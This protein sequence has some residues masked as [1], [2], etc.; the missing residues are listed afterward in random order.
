MSRTISQIYS[1]AIYVRNN[2]LQITELDS[3]RTGSK[4]SILNLLTYV[5]SVL[6][7]TYETILDVFQVNIAKLIASRI[8]GTA[9]WYVTM[10]KKFQYNTA[11]G[12]GDTFR[13]DDDTLTLEYDTVDESHRIIKQVAWEDY[14]SGDG[15]VLKVCKDNTDALQTENGMLY[16]PLTIPELNAFKRYIKAI[17]FIGAKIYCASLPG[18]IITIKTNG[19]NIYYDALYATQES[20]LESIK[21]SLLSYVKSLTYNGYIY[22]QSIID[23]IQNSEHIKNISAGIT[24]EVRR[25]N[26]VDNCY[27]VAEEITYQ[28]RPQSGYVGFIDENGETTINT[29]NLQLTA[30]E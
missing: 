6:I 25:W 27:D 12:S 7:Y 16:M 13:Y 15:I 21:T 28:Y 10:A 29:T 18:D 4:M 20:A 11:T 23:A 9:A 17:K 8:N 30:A 3:G 5:M 14:D 22:Y 1:E 26:V 24:I 2:Y 19:A